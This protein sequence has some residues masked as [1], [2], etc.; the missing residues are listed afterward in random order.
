MAKITPILGELRGSIAGNTFSRNTYGAYVRQRVAPIQPN[1]PYQMGLRSI[2]T[3]LSKRWTYILS[4]DKRNAWSDFAR[5]N[6]FTDPL[7]AVIYLSGIAM[8]QR[9]NALRLRVGEDVMDWP[10][11]DLWVPDFSLININLRPAIGE[12]SWSWNVDVPPEL[13]FI[14]LLSATPAVSPGVNY[15]RPFMREFFISVPTPPPPVNFLAK[16]VNRF[17]TP[18]EGNVH[19]FHARVYN[20]VNGAVSRGLAKKV[21]V[22]GAG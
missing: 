7:G 13:T 3:T 12:I 2:L 1:T 4:E 11:P 15:W 9:I 19:W 18:I 14:L 20:I 10:P 16:F 17:G 6:P 21:T 8:Y 22:L 5:L